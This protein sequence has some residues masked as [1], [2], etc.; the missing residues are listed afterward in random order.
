MNDHSTSLRIDAWLDLLQGSGYRLTGPRRAVVEILARSEFALNPT[1]IFIEAR[2]HYA[3]LGLVTIYRT[4]EKLEELDLV[5]RVHQPDGCHSYIAAGNG[6]EHLII[7]QKCN[8]AEYFSGD[9]LG[10]LMSRIGNEHGY[11]I[12][13]HWLQ[14]FGVCSY[15][16]KEEK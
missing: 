5:Q 15:C 13:D 10:G 7:C 16:R 1:Q 12:T 3:N 9:D 6:H 11:S 14:L 4:L 8:R 2:Q